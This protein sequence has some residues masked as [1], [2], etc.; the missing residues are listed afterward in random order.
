MLHVG[1]LPT[2]AVGRKAEVEVLEPPPLPWVLIDPGM[3]HK[4]ARVVVV[5]RFPSQHG[6]PVVG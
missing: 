4:V 2:E 3:R 5:G 6:G 1:G